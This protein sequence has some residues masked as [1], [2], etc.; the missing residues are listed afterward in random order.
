[1]FRGE[2]GATAESAM[3]FNDGFS[4]L[5]VDRDFPSQPFN[6]VVLAGANIFGLKSLLNL[7][8]VSRLAIDQSKCTDPVMVKPEGLPTPVVNC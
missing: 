1:M 8:V 3:K 5:W 4:W 6:S 7:F 2:G